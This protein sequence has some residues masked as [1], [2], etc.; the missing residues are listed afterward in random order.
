MRFVHLVA[1]GVFSGQGDGR[2]GFVRGDD[3]DA[4]VLP[5]RQMPRMPLP[6]PMSRIVPVSG[7]RRRAWFSR[8]SLS[9]RG[10]STSGETVNSRPLK[11]QLR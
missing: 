8:H 1:A 6:Q 7:Q 2:E 10:M 11:R 3:P 9:G 5:A 4:G